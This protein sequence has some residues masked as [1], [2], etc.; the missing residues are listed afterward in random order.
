MFKKNSKMASWSLILSILTLLILASTFVLANTRLGKN[1]DLFNNA[2][3]K[4]DLEKSYLEIERLISEKEFLMLQLKEQLEKYKKLENENETLQSE[5]EI[6]H[7]QIDELMLKIASLEKDVSKLM[8]LKKELQK[9]KS[10]FQ[11]QLTENTTLKNGK[12]TIATKGTTPSLNTENALLETK[13]TEKKVDNNSPIKDIIRD[14]YDNIRLLNSSIQTYFKKDSGVK[15]PHTLATKVNIL[16]LQYTLYADK[17][18]NKRENIFYIQIFDTNNKNVGK[19]KSIYIG[20]KELVY[21][22]KSIV[23]YEEEI[24]SIKEEFSTEGLDLD[25]GVYF[26]NIFSENGKLLSSR[27]FKLD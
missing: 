15:K 12:N 2:A 10:E 8:T 22:F 26:L 13:V 9:A 27:S 25:K 20:E 19:T 14:E 11:N 23:A 6:K 4:S 16:E 24:N 5:L 7:Q 3:L 17:N 21:S 18:S 1:I